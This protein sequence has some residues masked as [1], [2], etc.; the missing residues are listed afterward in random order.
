MV[1]LFLVL[2]GEYPGMFMGRILRTEDD[3][4]ST[5]QRQIGI[6]RKFALI[7]LTSNNCLLLLSQHTKLALNLHSR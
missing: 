7:L 1:E 3:P 4:S 5:W 2:C 6:N